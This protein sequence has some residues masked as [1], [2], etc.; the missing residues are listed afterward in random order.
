MFPYPATEADWE[1]LSRALCSQY[2][3]DIAQDAI[4]HLLEKSLKNETLAIP[5]LY[6]CRMDAAKD[7]LNL[8]KQDNRH[9]ELLQ[10]IPCE[11]HTGPT[12]HVRAEL[13]TVAA[14]EG[15]TLRQLARA[16]RRKN[17]AK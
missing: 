5:A 9:R 14:G 6:W 15:R 12:Q 3:E 13:S 2:P 7:I 10:D 8:R 16:R 1:A 11:G 4:M 17:R